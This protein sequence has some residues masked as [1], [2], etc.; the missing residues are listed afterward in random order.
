MKTVVVTPFALMAKPF[1][2]EVI[3]VVTLAYLRWY[4]DRKYVAPNT[5][6]RQAASA[7]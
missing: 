2:P 3:R 4:M 5:I 1:Y 7:V 6:S